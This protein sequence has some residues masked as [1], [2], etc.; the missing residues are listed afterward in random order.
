[1]NK[2][3]KDKTVGILRP[4][5]MFMVIV[6]VVGR[7][8]VSAYGQESIIEVDHEHEMGE[9]IEVIAA[10]SETKGLEE[11]KCL[12]CEYTEEREIPALVTITINFF[13]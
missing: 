4:F 8:P 1:M 2:Q 12:H 3:G 7:L 10:T 11:S 5:A 13:N 6:L 9:W